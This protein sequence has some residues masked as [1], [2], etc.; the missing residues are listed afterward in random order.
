MDK[1]EKLILFFTGVYFATT[2]WIAGS[3]LNTFKDAN[4]I[5]IIISLTLLFLSGTTFIMLVKISLHNN[6]SNKKVYQY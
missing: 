1:G 3:I 5:S 6:I 2:I 4:L